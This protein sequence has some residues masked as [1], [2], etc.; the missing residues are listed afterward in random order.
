MYYRDSLVIAQVELTNHC[1]YTCIGCPRTY[2]MTRPLGFMSRETFTAVIDAVQANQR[3]WGPLSIHHMGE[4]ML[5]PE[6]A[7]FIA[8]ATSRGVPTA[9]ACRPNHLPPAKARKLLEAGLAV[10]V[11]SIDALDTPTLKQISGKVA[12]YPAAKANVEALLAL[13]RELGAP[14]QILLQM[15]GYSQNQH[16]WDDFLAQWRPE[17]GFHVSLKR[18]ASWTMPQLGKHAGNGVVH[19]GPACRLPFQT[20][21]VLWDG[22]VALCNRDHDGKQV[23]GHVSEGLLNVWHGENYQRFRA[24]FADDELPADAMCRSCDKYPWRDGVKRTA[25]SEQTWFGGEAVE[26]KYSADWWLEAFGDRLDPTL[27]S[28][29]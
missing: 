24:A 29:G 20:C 6:I 9:L 23:F 11:V 13:K 21:V 18:F 10:L 17:E 22:R 12:D 26:W 2:E 1:P 16:Q 7:D 28:A 15:I 14:T 4:S 8:L 25:D 5:H 27:R 19:I 3:D